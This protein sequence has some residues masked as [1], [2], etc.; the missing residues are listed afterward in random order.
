VRLRLPA[1]IAVATLLFAIGVAAEPADE[2][3]DG[4]AGTEATEHVAGEEGESAE[5]HAAEDGAGDG[6][7]SEDLLG[8]DVESTPLV[9]VAVAVSL[10]LALAAY[11][12]PGSRPLLFVIAVAMIAF[13]ALDIREVVH[14][15]DE[16]NGGVAAIA[17][18][19]AVL[20]LAASGVA[21]GQARAG[22]GYSPA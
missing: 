3:H 4:G 9:I 7:E 11:L 15:I 22:A 1:L 21:W 17:A 5:V 18:V 20:H 2:H 16:S 10:L 6:D 13:A 12:R 19:V 14:Q 8:V